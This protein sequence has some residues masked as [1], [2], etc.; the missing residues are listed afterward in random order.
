MY[1][2]IPRME[3]RLEVALLFKKFCDKVKNKSGKLPNGKYRRNYMQLAI[4]EFLKYCARRDVCIDAARALFYE[5]RA[6]W[7]SKL[8]DMEKFPCQIRQVQICI[9]NPESI[10]GLQI[11]EEE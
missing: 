4:D 8:D 6:F 9:Y 11:C 10:T 2:Q 1:I 7:Y 5:N 3:I